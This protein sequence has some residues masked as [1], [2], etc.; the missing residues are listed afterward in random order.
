MSLR[1]NQLTKF[2]G[3]QV[4]INAISF[5]AREGEILGF[6]GPNGAG[7]STTMKIATAYLPPSHGSV[8]VCG[9]NVV[10]DSLSVRKMV[11][12]LPEHNPLYLE[13]YVREYLR[14]IGS[15]YKLSGKVLSQRVD[16]MIDLCGLELEQHK[17]ISSLS[18]GYRQ[19]VGLAQALIH[20]PKVLILD[21]PTTGLDPNQLGEIRRLIK[22][23]SREKTVIFSTHIMQE[24]QALCD[25][26]V[27]INRGNI[28]IN[29]SM[30]ELKNQG[31]KRGASRQRVE[32][33]FAN[34]V[35]T[36]LLEELV[37]VATVDP[38]GQHRYRVMAEEGTGDIR[39]ALFQFACKQGHV[40]LEMRQLSSEAVSE[41]GNSLEEIF[42]N[43]TVNG[44]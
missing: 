39:P 29:A 42:R 17:L 5:E 41:Y 12:Y 2:F 21:E 13:M 10:E 27:I 38:I 26:V 36:A 24:V 40:L 19:R 11:G 16:K 18:K 32:L 34:K 14:F 37:D 28:V 25:R 8:Q 30:D 33:A 20:D 3:K 4:A 31:Q 23:I 22:E 44:K 7:K 35:E 6:L 43:L 1:V 9:K 15:M